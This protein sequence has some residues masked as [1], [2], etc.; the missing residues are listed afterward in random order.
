ME[1]MIMS[2]GPVE[3]GQFMK[4]REEA[5]R[6][7]VNGNASPLGRLVTHL[8]PATFFGPAGGVDQGPER[9]CAIYERDAARFQSGDS[10]FE[11]LQTGAS[12][13]LAYWVGIQRASARLDGNQEAIPMNL[14]VT[15]VFRREGRD[16]K[17]VHRHAD[18]LK[19]EPERVRK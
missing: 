10:T 14:R 12:D 11:I 6:G 18:V 1:A 16:W 17:L 13:S 19:S 5:A 7:F 8:P 15:E 9:V 4:Q 3:F 2:N